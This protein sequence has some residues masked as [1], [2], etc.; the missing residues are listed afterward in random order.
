MQAERS[1]VDEGHLKDTFINCTSSFVLI[2]ENK[3]FFSHTYTYKHK[4]KQR[5][6]H[7]WCIRMLHVHHIC[8]HTIV[9]I[10]SIILL[11]TVPAC[12]YLNINR[13][14]SCVV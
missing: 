7:I 13:Q 2:W 3:V 6:L 11:G 9:S 5:M 10:P 8:K 12:N 4:V 1:R 14:S